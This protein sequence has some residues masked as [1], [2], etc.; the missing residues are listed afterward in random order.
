MSGGGPGSLEIHPGVLRKLVERFVDDAPE[1]AR[2]C[3][4]R[5]T[6]TAPVIDIALRLALRYPAPVRDAAE[7][8]RDRLVAEV[9]RVTGY[10][11]RRLDV[12]VSAL[13]PRG[14]K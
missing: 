8:V 9:G 11:V 1:T 14:D 5:I 4:A 13:V 2:E 3:T 12:T 7:A 10:H 6:G